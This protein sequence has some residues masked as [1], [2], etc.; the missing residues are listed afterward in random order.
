M[1]DWIPV[2]GER[3]R[4]LVLHGNPIATVVSYEEIDSAWRRLEIRWERPDQ[5]R[6]NVWYFGPD[7]NR[8]YVLSTTFEPILDENFW[9]ELELQ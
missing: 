5:W 4:C 8:W 2:A 6:G 7:V 9:S 1:S 3:V